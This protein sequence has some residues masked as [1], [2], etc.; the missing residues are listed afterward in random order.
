M[1]KIIYPNLSYKI[2]GLCF[3]AQ[4]ELRRFCRE[5][6]Y[7]DKLEELLI[8]EKLAYGREVEIKTLNNKSPRGNVIDFIIENKIIVDLKAKSYITKSDY[9]QM[10]RY[11]KSTNIKLGLIINFRNYHLKPKRV[12]NSEYYSQS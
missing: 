3:K 5:R 4:K 2:T 1:S 8:N 12:L 10:Q 6:Q 11:L 9:I 7:D